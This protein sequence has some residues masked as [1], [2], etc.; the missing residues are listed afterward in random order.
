VA[1]VALTFDDGPNSGTTLQVV[2]ALTSQNIPATFFMLGSMAQANPSVVARI[3]AN[4]RFEIGNHSVSH[5]NLTTL[6]AS[7]V[8][9]QVT[10][11]TATL[12]RLTG[13]KITL[14]RPPYGSHNATVD[15]ACR[16]AGQS[17]ILWDVDTLDWQNRNAAT[18]TAR[19][20]S[21]ARAG[22]IILMHDI[23]PSTAAAV[24]E[25]VAQLRGRGFVLVTVSELL[26]STVPGK[27]YTRRG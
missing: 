27:A 6:G 4:P 2:N 25:I 22:S 19:A 21:Q 12:S 13:R 26:G 8:S 24:P 16:T 20:V 18:T 9:S 14:F 7:Q 15:T 1:C 17:L 10:S 23:H 3:A 5:P 11:A